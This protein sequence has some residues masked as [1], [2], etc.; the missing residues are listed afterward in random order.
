MLRSTPSSVRF[1]EADEIETKLRGNRGGNKG[2][3]GGGQP[4][5]DP[6]VVGSVTIPVYVHV[7]NKGSGITNGDVSN[8]MITDQINV[9]NN[10]YGGNTGGCRL[11]FI[12]CSWEPTIRRMRP[13]IQPN[14]A[15]LQRKR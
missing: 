7:I 13:G 1:I 9:L 4:P 11:S 6:P 3:P 14:L 15:H 5:S 12:L 2:G 10:A 8:Q